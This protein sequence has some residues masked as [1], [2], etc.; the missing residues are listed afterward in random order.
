MAR[1]MGSDPIFPLQERIFKALGDAFPE[2]TDTKW[3]HHV[4]TF[5]QMID[6]L[7]GHL[8]KSFPKEAEKYGKMAHQG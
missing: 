8:E 7:W 1:K 5:T 6:F 4:Q 2:V 3:P